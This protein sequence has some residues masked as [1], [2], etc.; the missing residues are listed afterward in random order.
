MDRAIPGTPHQK[1][2]RTHDQ[3]DAEQVEHRLAHQE[4]IQ[5]L[6]ERLRGRRTTANQILGD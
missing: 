2:H 1:D 4:V 5:P 3:H 6:A